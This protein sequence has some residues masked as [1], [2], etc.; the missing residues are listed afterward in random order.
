[1][2]AYRGGNNRARLGGRPVRG[3]SAIFRNLASNDTFVDFLT[4][5]ASERID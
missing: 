1:M 5:Q 4:L 2:D 3:G